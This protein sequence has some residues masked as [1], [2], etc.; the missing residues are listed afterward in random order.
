MSLVQNI[1]GGGSG[2]L[3]EVDANNQLKVALPLT[4]SKMGGV[5]M[6]CQNDAGQVSGNPQ[7]ASPETDTWGRLRVSEDS[8]LEEELFNYTAQNTGK[9]TIIA[10]ATNL[11]PSW[12][13][14]GYNTNPTGIVTSGSGATLQSYQYFPQ[15][16]M[17]VLGVNVIASFS[18][19][20]TTNTIVDFGLFLGAASNPFA[21][22][23][24][25]YFRLNSG[26]LQGIVNFNGVETSTGIF[27]LSGGTGVWV[28]T[29]NQ[30][31]LFTIRVSNCNVEFWVND[32]TQS[33]NNTYLL[34]SLPTP[35]G[36]GTPYLS[37]SLPF[38]VRHAIAGGTA[39]AALNMIISR[40]SIR[41]GSGIQADTMSATYS[42]TL[43]TYQGLSG[44]TLGSLMGGTVTTGTIVA[45][46]AAVPTNTTNALG[47][48]G[49][50]GHVY[51]TATLAAGTDGILISYQ[52]PVG[53]VAVQG[54][55][56]KISGVS[57]ASYVQTVLAGGPCNARYYLAFGHTAVSLQTAEA[58][59]TKAPRRVNLPFIQTQTTAQAVSTSVAQNQYD[60]KF[61]N[62]VYVNPGEFV[63]LVMA[64]VGTA[65]TSGVIAHQICFDYSWE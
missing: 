41:L 12:T 51:E 30:K 42:R 29:L 4:P 25:A 9:H 20:P 45:P 52:V 61:V 47:V 26:G 59:T 58:S 22:T 56:L 60:F 37:A 43:G 46:T 44:G 54:R 15:V 63:Q 17:A 10:G 39:G 3:A 64:R 23:D 36:Q 21:P 8:T 31:Y 57:L 1:A 38:H 35:V 40:Y 24:G 62:P 65:F 18:A 13:T 34:G 11:V 27:D 28:Y 53:T 2:I 33:G 50:G 7:I 19:A 55:R 32:G 5:L 14:G 6:M 48:T 49:L 16:S